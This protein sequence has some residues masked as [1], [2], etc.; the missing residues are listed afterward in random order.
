MP[1]FRTTEYVDVDIDIDV[2]EFFD[3]MDDSEKRE[4]FDLLTEDGFGTSNI[5][6]YTNWEFKNAIEKLSENYYQLTN[7]EETLIIKLSK[8]F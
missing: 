5:D 3:K 7:E 4:M 6:S 8:R 2:D 1:E